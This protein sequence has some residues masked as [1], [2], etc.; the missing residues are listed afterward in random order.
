MHNPS[1]GFVIVLAHIY[2]IICPSTV[3]KEM[4][5]SYSWSVCFPPRN[6]RFATNQGNLDGQDYLFWARHTFSNQT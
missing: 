3:E 5:L 4:S 6:E 1:N 2:T